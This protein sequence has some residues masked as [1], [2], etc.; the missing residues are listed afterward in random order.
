MVQKKE[1]IFYAALGQDFNI[2]VEVVVFSSAH[3]QLI[4]HV[5]KTLRVLSTPREIHLLRPET[6]RVGN[7]VFRYRVT[8]NFMNLTDDDFGNY[9]IMAG[10]TFGYD[11][12]QFE[13]VNKENEGK[14]NGLKV[15]YHLE[16]CHHHP[17]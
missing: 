6:N 12:F 11:V 8:F 4:Q 7:D 14:R 3:F 1:R 15:K 5:N 2:S 13:L 10:N 9:S 17:W 16:K